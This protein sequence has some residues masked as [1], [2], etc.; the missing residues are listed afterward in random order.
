MFE[1]CVALIF[2]VNHV[3]SLYW[4]TLASQMSEVTTK[5]VLCFISLHLCDITGMTVN[6]L[7]R[8]NV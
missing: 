1:K 6:H 2:Y 8:L 5:Y 3:I 7:K 4:V